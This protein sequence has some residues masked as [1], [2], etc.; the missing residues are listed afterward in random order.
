MSKSLKDISA[1]VNRI[2]GTV[3]IK[4]EPLAPP[5]WLKSGQTLN[6]NL[7]TNQAAQR[8]L[9]PATALRRSGDRTVVLVV[10]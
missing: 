8:L 3:S 2:R 9:V 6:V 10:Q 7:V 4:L 1:S 5:A